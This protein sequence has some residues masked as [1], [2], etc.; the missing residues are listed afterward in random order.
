MMPQQMRNNLG[1]GFAPETSKPLVHA[2]EKVTW[3][4]DFQLND[5]LSKF[6]CHDSPR[7]M[8]STPTS[9]R[10]MRDTPSY[11]RFPLIQRPQRRK[12]RFAVFD[13]IRTYEKPNHAGRKQDLWWSM[14]ELARNRDVERIQACRDLS[15]QQYVRAYIHAFYEVNLGKSYV[16]EKYMLALVEGCDWGHCGLMNT[17]S[18]EWQ[19]MRRLDVRCTVASV[20][21]FYQRALQYAPSNMDVSYSLCAHSKTL[22]RSHRKMAQVIGEANI[23]ALQL[24]SMDE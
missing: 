17:I 14:E 21:S 20:V 3:S 2:F 1:V 18:R 11:D 16:S 15:A 23:I 24:D 19:C 4:P 22:T 5:S 12:V 13:M 8:S 10:S 7:S 9:L 6:M